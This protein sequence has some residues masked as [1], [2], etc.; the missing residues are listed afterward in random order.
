MNSPA[1][2]VSEAA[3]H[4]GPPLGVVAIVC[5]TLFLAGLYPVTMFGGMPYFPG[6]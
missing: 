1:Q 4:R 2:I 5:V 3:R 6:P